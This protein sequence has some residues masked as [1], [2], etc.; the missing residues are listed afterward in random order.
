MSG[1][2]YGGTNAHVILETVATKDKEIRV[3]ME[4][5][6]GQPH[7]FANGLSNGHTNGYVNGVEEIE[8]NGVNGH[9]NAHGNDLERQ[10]PKAKGSL[11]G[12]T[13]NTTSCPQLYV[14]SAASEVSLSMM[15]SHLK[16][17]LSTKE[18]EGSQ[19]RDVSYT[20]AA[21]R[22]LH[23]WRSAIV[24]SGAHD[25]VEQLNLAKSIKSS[26]VC[27]PAV[28]FIFTGQGAQWYAMGRELLPCTSVF[29]DSISTSSELLEHWGT[30]WSLHQELLKNDEHS[31]L[32]ES[33]L[34]QPATTAIQIAL[35]DLLLHV[36]ITPRRVCG[37]SS[38]EIGAAYAAGALSH[39]SALK[40]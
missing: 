2:G 12:I 27:P 18:L 14:L 20:L 39:E 26:G 35:V 24:A 10:S 9:Q 32:S 11:T 17:W 38:G 33:E 13:Q 37:H 40:V 30:S 7:S 15:A 19:L 22:S 28:T 21:R 25:L 31:R 8:T 4:D 34:A 16:A 23:G 29:R 6:T 1:F 3:F 5:E 36:G